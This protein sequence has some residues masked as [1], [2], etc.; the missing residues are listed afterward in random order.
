MNATAQPTPNLR[1]LS[2]IAKAVAALKLLCE[3]I[4]DP[5]VV[6]DI[7][8]AVTKL[9]LAYLTLDKAGVPAPEPDP[10]ADID[11]A[12]MGLS[13][14]NLRKVA[15]RV[16]ERLRVLRQ[17][18]HDE[19]VPAPDTERSTPKSKSSN[20]PPNERGAEDVLRGAQ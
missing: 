17:L 3:T 20:P 11:D 5:L 6:A 18:E 2:V 8:V 16:D 10:V 12:L 7:G 9:S 1:A 13:A 19:N 14:I 4:P 15:A